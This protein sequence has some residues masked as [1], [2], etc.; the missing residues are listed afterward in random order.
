MVL[1]PGCGGCVRCFCFAG[2]ILCLLRVARVCLWGCVNLF[3]LLDF[4]HAV[5]VLVGGVC[6]LG[7]VGIVYWCC[8]FAVGCFVVFC[9]WLMLVQ[10][11]WRAG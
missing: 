3:W 4:I 2:L 11:C 7:F 9:G 5:G 10:A 6:R 1:L 8:W